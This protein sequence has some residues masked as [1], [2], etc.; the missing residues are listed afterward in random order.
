MVETKMY[1]C[2]KRDPK[3]KV[4]FKDG[5]GA[6]SDETFG[7]YMADFDKKIN[8]ALKNTSPSFS[9]NELFGSIDEMARSFNQTSHDAASTFSRNS[10]FGNPGLSQMIN[11]TPTL[12]EILGFS[13]VTSQNYKTSVSS[14]MSE[15]EDTKERYR[16]QLLDLQKGVRFA[17]RIKHQRSLKTFAPYQAEVVKTDLNLLE[18][19]FQLGLKTYMGENAELVCFFPLAKSYSCLL[20]KCSAK[21]FTGQEIQRTFRLHINGKGPSLDDIVKRI[22][23]LFYQSTNIDDDH[24]TIV[25]IT[26]D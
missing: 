24:M 7:R 18:P 16:K 3:K 1:I 26:T 15:L 4:H 2:Y 22:R 23:N 9:F 14:Q 20:I 6:M 21:G 25:N 10:N 13:S 19:E 11:K 5:I 8:Q 17:R 12:D